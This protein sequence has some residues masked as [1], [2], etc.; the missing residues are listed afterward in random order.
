MKHPIAFGL[1]AVLLP[2][3]APALRAASLTYSQPTLPCMALENTSGNTCLIT[4]TNTDPSHL[5]YVTNIS[6]PARFVPYAGESDD[7][8]INPA[9]VAPN[10][11]AQNPLVIAL[12]GGTANIKFSWDAVDYVMDNDVDSGS[13]L[14]SFNVTYHYA[15]GS[16]MTL[17]VVADVQVNDPPRGTPEPATFLAIGLGLV[18]LGGYRFRPRRPAPSAQPK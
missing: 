10:P 11:T 4:L 16:N 17:L 8:A 12:K 7:Q 5:V 9:L 13:W 3:A 2:A 15:G 14:T 6:A 18:A 1:L